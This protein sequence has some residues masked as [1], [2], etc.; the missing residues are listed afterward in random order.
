MAIENLLEW[1]ITPVSGADQHYISYEHKWHAR[2][3]T[4]AW[5]VVIPAGV[6]I[7]RYFKVTKSQKWPDQLD[8]LFWWHAHRALQIASC[9]AACWAVLYVVDWE[10]MS[11]E[12]NAV[13]LHEIL[14]W[15]VMLLAAGQLFGPFLRGSKGEPVDCLGDH[16]QM[17]RRRCVFEILHKSGGYLALLVAMLTILLGLYNTD[18]P[19]WMWIVIT[20]YWTVLGLVATVLQKQG[21]CVDTYQAIY[22]PDSQ[23]PGNQRP[24]I[25][26]GIRRYQSGEWPPG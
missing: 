20:G 10:L 2:F 3:M 22:G 9:L 5:G 16:I 8:N 7:A 17:T 21:R 12:K 14:G 18:A 25:G 24:P 4:L 26:W 19:R 6:L 13:N 1:M 23:L 15:L 11:S